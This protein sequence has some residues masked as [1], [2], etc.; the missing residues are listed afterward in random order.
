[1]E[2]LSVPIVTETNRALIITHSFKGVLILFVIYF[3]L[4][5][6]S[7]DI[8]GVSGAIRA[9][10]S[11]FGFCLSFSAASFIVTPRINLLPR[12]QRLSY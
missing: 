12:L 3:V 8:V 1:M 7:V 5:F 4:K 6:R 10:L 9:L 2:C 11:V